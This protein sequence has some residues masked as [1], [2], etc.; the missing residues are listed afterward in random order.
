M[1]AFY[2][3]CERAARKERIAAPRPDD[4]SCSKKVCVPCAIQRYAKASILEKI[5]TQNKKFPTEFNCP[6]TT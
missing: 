3:D 5:K 6:S 1:D 2:A 4:L